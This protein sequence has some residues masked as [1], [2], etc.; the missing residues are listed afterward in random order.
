MNAIEA[1]LGDRF[2]SLA[3][4]L[5][6][7]FTSLAPPVRS[8]RGVMTRVWR[9]GGIALLA[10][11]ILRLSAWDE[12]LFTETGQHVP[13]EL[14]MHQQRG[15]TAGQARHMGSEATSDLTLIREYAFP[16]GPVRSFALVTFDSKARQLLDRLGR[17]GRLE[18]ELHPTIEADG[19]LLLRSGRQWLRLSPGVRIRIPA[20][21][22]GHAVVREWQE[23][24]GAIG[25]SV[26]VSN[27]ILGPFFGYE[28]SF[29]ETTAS[30]ERERSDSNEKCPSMGAASNAQPVPATAGGAV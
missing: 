19:S 25:I 18:V 10:A 6:A 20:L 23:P 17:H 29:T 7:Y 5:R 15:P 24:S 16:T 30:N 11:P 27:P 1:A 12:V 8:F 28:G 9:R 2:E 13:F 21:L 22:A 14:T 3:P 26:V 4:A